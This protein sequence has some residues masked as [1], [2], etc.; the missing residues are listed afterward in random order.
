MR[1]TRCAAVGRESRYVALPATTT[2]AGL[3]AEIEFLSSDPAVDG[4]LLQHPVPDH[5]DE[6]AAFEAI[7]PGKD[8]DGVTMH[9]F[10]AMA[11]NES[12]FHSCTPGGI[13]RQC[14]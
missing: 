9:S 2:T 14:R 5:I 8:V 11:F 6:H 7:A 3:I 1:R 4:I 10:A 12:G 13:M